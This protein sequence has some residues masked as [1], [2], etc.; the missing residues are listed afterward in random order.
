M[1]KENPGMLACGEVGGLPPAGFDFG[2]SPTQTIKLDLKGCVLVQ[3]TGAGTQGI[4]RSVKAEKLVAASFVVANATVKYIQQLEPDMVTFV[5]TGKYDES[6]GDEDQA[7]DEY[8]EALLRADDPNP[9][10]FLQ[11]VRNSRDAKLFE[12]PERPEFP[13][14]DIAYCT[15]LNRFD[16]AMPVTQENGRFVMCAITHDF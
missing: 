3:R 4:V 11:R 1:K 7:C 15:D 8:L 9:E 6:S 12:D 2:N 13:F 16:F 14:S 10:P 5:V